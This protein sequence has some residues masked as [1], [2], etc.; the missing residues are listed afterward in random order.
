MG[1]TLNYRRRQGLRLLLWWHGSSHVGSTLIRAVAQLPTGDSPS[2]LASRVSPRS[3]PCSLRPYVVC[4][5][6][7]RRQAP[8]KM[9]GPP[10]PG[11]RAARQQSRHWHSPVLIP[12]P[13]RL[14]HYPAGYMFP[15]LFDD[16]PLLLRSQEA[17]DSPFSA[18]SS[19]AAH[20][21]RPV[22]DRLGAHPASLGRAQ[23]SQGAPAA[24][25]A[26]P[27]RRAGRG[28][29]IFCCILSYSELP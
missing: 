18:L 23:V 3:T 20:H 24:D 28:R 8:D 7:H 22:A 17:A 26:D 14:R 11:W 5:M 27:D 19:R 29:V 15:E 10:Q 21:A 2:W 6:Q 4:C 13:L 9:D 12:Y 25:P 1:R 16:T